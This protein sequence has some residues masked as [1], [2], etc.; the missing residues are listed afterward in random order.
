MS[1]TIPFSDL[2]LGWL[3]ESLLPDFALAFTFFTALA[4]AVLGRRF[5]H[6]RPAVAMSAAIGLALAV[7]LVWWEQERG[8]SVKNLGPFAIGFAVILVGMIMFQAIRQTGGSWSGAGIALGASILMASLLGFDWPGST[9]IIPAIALIALIV[10][11]VAFLGHSRRAL[12]PA[13]YVAPSARAETVDVRHDMSDLYDDNRAGEALRQR[14]R[15]L[16]EAG[17]QLS[18]HPQDFGNVMAQLQQTLP[19][20]GWLTERLARLR[21]KAHA[22]RNG[23]VARITE[24]R[25]VLN[26]L[27]PES[28]K[29]ASQE[30]AARY[31][32]LRLDKRLERLD[33]ATAENERRIREITREAEEALARYDYRKL[34]DLME[35]A[36]KLQGHNSELFKA[37]DRTE[38][39]L[40]AIAQGVA[41]DAPGEAAK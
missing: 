26:R 41:K 17:S 25:Q 35:A 21:A 14:F 18:G 3:F 37:I 9:G 1:A 11:I 19:A 32:E 2:S 36:E 15:R 33:R 38:Q 4:Y 27:P 29:A 7:G 28:R 6:Q 31:E 5:D 34:T 40:A 22:V 24:L 39:K 23:H 8:L 30:L 10:G 12:P 16:R 13:T 20:E